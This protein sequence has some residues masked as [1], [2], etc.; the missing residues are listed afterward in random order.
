M[1]VAI[2]YDG[3]IADTNR[4]KSEWIKAHLGLQ[5]PPWHCSRTDCVPIIGEDAYRQLGDWVY[6]RTSTLQAEA[7]PGALDALHLL[8]KQSE[9]HIVT[10]RPGRRIVFACE[11]LENKGV[12][13]LFQGIRTSAGTSKAEICA[14]LGADVLVDD[15]LRHVEKAD[16]E[17]MLRILMQYG[18]EGESD[19]GPQV[20]FCSSWEQVLDLV[21][22]RA[23]GIG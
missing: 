1:I 9:L 7:L 5:V 17:G 22:Q 11:W 14:D 13:D 2:D 21:E 15:D 23:R 16:V 10:A 18:R 12:L 20:V 3:T 8:A 19:C 4:A 6:E